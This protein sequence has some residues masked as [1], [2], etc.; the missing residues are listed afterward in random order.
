M[1]IV[2]Q[3]SNNL[4]KAQHVTVVSGLV[5]I[6]ISI[7]KVWVGVLGH[8]NALIAD[9]IHSLSDLLSDILVW[10]V[11]RIS[12][13]GADADHPYGHGRFE[14][15]GTALLGALLIFVAG[16]LAMENIRVLLGHAQAHV[17]TWPVLI[18]ALL[19]IFI[20]EW[21]Y[22]Y[23]VK[24][25]NELNS[26]LLIANAW[27]SR[28][29]AISAVL[30]LIGAG[31]AML[32]FPW[33]DSAVALLIYIYMAWVGW[34]FFLQSAKELVD[35]H[36]L[37][38]QQQADIKALIKTVD[39]VKDIHE[40]RARQMGSGVVLDV[41][42]QVLPYISVSEGHHIAEW[43]M[44]VLQ[45]DNPHLS[46][47]VVHIDAEPDFYEGQLDQP[48]LPLRKDI[49]NSC[50]ERWKSVDCMPDRYKIVLHFNKHTVSVDVFC[51]LDF[52]QEKNQ[53]IESYQNQ[54][55]EQLIDLPWINR[56]TVWV[57]ST[58]I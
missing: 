55:T 7:V 16:A 13:T 45:E 49:L 15:L 37:T 50:E 35:S 18:I 24:V 42:V 56:V 30:V 4:A 3:P 9:G 8:S 10:C 23:L 52:L 11:N 33:I 31:C 41:H 32:G 6:L 5:N 34:K 44:K 22:R 17:P 25:G 27:H 58:V 51:S 48:L 28:T 38:E 39:G 14:A 26:Q 20:K 40:L 43:V 36:A 19:S 53:T 47:I 12:F 2:K 54:L 46:D 57:G 21:L 29:D 1:T